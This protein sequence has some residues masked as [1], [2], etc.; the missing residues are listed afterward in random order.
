MCGHLNVITGGGYS[1]MSVYRFF[2]AIVF[3]F[4]MQ[5][6]A[7]VVLSLLVALSEMVG[8]A[9][10]LPLLGLLLSDNSAVDTG[11]LG[12]FTHWLGID[13][14]SAGSLLLL[15]AM[16][17]IIRDAAQ[18]LSIFS[19]N[20]SR[21]VI[22]ARFRRDY[23]HDMLQVSYGSIQKQNAGSMINIITSQ[24][25][26]IGIGVKLLGNLMSNVVVAGAFI[27]SAVILEPLL[28][29]LLAPI[30][31]L[32]VFV[33]RYSSR[34]TR[35]YAASNIELRAQI[36]TSVN[37]VLKHFK[38]IK[39]GALEPLYESQLF[40]AIRFFLRNVRRNLIVQFASQTL[41]QVVSLVLVFALVYY[42]L[43]LQ[44]VDKQD[45][46]MVIVLL[47][48]ASGRI[49]STQT[50]WRALSQSIPA[51][52]KVESSRTVLAE[53]KEKQWSDGLVPAQFNHLS[54]TDINFHYEQS[55]AVLSDFN[56]V[57]NAKGLVAISG[58][59]G[60]GKTTF[61]D[62]LTGI[63]RP[64]HGIVRIDDIPLDQL[65][66]KEWRKQIAYIPQDCLLIKG[67]I[68]ENILLGVPESV[69]DGDFQSIC[70][71]C[72]VDDF[73][74]AFPD[75]YETFIEDVGA[76]VSGGQRQRILIARA[77]L[78]RKPIILLDEAMSAVDGITENK[79]FAMLRKFAA[80]HLIVLIAHRLAPLK[81]ADHIVVMDK[82]TV[83]ESGSYEV[84]MRGGGLFSEMV[85][86]WE[87]TSSPEA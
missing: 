37:E 55:T 56:L 25:D 44:D 41:P 21:A 40:T 45:V 18:N 31:L 10:A 36:V 73:V 34:L 35:I 71:A 19:I 42:Y 48:R 78:S 77:M 72:L 50:D 70:K 24:I 84:L 14:L 12:D 15:L 81:F 76:T 2:R 9:S 60:A 79:L 16:L 3:R 23:V 87:E 80:D 20:W 83:V 51:F 33:A 39:S 85:N 26:A 17:L 66:L 86:Q 52:E 13:A 47:Y 54:F 65:D 69:E 58:P 22:E 5:T 11:F 49:I 62:I 61:V 8:L 4:P 63:A 53:N 59:S 43:G 27:L 67:T 7:I 64:Q 38:F 1:D 75:G 29:A 32:S 57:L 28:L 46:L 68:R 6:G 74:Q 30:A 82:G